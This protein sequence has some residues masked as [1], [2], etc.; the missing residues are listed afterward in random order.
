MKKQLIPKRH[1]LLTLILLL[2]LTAV[3]ENIDADPLEYDYGTVIVGTSKF[4]KF[5][6]RSIGPY[7]PLTIYDITIVYDDNGEFLLDAVVPDDPLEVGGEIEVM[8]TFTP[9][10]EGMASAS[11]L[12]DSDALNFPLLYIPLQGEGI[13]ADPTPTGMMDYLMSF[14]YDSVANETILGIGT[15]KRAEKRIDKFEVILYSAD[16]AIDASDDAVACEELDD[17][18]YR[19]DGIPRPN[20]YLVGPAVPTLSTL[21]ILVMDSLGCP[22]AYGTDRCPSWMRAYPPVGAPPSVPAACGKR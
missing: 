14:F 10:A 22:E 1:W 21:I 11:L 13:T 8:V 3:A 2:P 20:D 15:G 12:V 5:T 6:I 16:A 9:R 7:T 4:M 17:A 19:I 18:Y